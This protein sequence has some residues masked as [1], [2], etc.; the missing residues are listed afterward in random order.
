MVNE[1]DF[2][3]DTEKYPLYNQSQWLSRMAH[4]NSTTEKECWI[5]VKRGKTPPED[6]FVVS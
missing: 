1:K 2:V 6:A 5:A 4:K 3:N